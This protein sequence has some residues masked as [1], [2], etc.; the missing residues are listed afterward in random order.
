MELE[1]VQLY[2]LSDLRSIFEFLH[3]LMEDLLHHQI[4]LFIL[5]TVTR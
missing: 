2:S 1:L 5:L 4:L 3:G